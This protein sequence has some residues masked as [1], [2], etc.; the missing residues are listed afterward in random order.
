MPGW[1]DLIKGGSKFL[2]GQ[3]SGGSGKAGGGGGVLATLGQ[4]SNMP[5]QAI[6]GLATSLVQGIQASRLKKKADAAFPELTDPRQTSFLAELNQKRKSLDMG[7]AYASGMNAIDTTNAGTNDAIVKAAGGDTG[8]T[9]QALIQSQAASGAAKNNVL[10]Q[11]QQQQYAYTKAAEDLNNLVSARELQLGLLRH[12]QYQA[13]W[14]KKS[15]AAGANLMAGV[16]AL[17]EQKQDYAAP[18]TG[19]STPPTNFPTNYGLAPS[20][21]PPANPTPTPP[22][23]IETTGAPAPKAVPEVTETMKGLGPVMSLVKR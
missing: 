4:R 6:T 20:T 7:A 2:G 18:S 9:L 17:N 1:M 8:A 14:D 15:N 16:A 5:K 19:T 13:Q 12:N 21:P 22:M 11:G 10:A 23:S 3:Q